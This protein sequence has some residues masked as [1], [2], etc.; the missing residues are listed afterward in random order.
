MDYTML[1]KLVLAAAAAALFALPSAAAVAGSTFYRWVDED[2]SIHYSPTKPY[3]VKHIE[4]INT[5]FTSKQL[6]AIKQSN[7]EKAAELAVR[8]QDKLV[9]QLEQ[10]R[11]HELDRLQTCVDSAFDKMAY[12]KRHIDDNSVKKKIECE[13]KYDRSRQS[14]KYDQCV[15]QVEAARLSNLKIL[16]QSANHCFGPETDPEMINEVMAKYREAPGIESTDVTDMNAASAGGSDE[17]TAPDVN[18]KMK[19]GDGEEKAGE[20]EGE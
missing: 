20:K 1:R 2:G 10:Q 19:T 3:G 17:S 16:E 12:Q 11:K 4:S 13:Y 18:K 6:E 5:T 9:Q 14:A 7:K 8:N 15:L